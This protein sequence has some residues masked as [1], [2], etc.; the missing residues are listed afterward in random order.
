MRPG[1]LLVSG[2]W[3]RPESRREDGV[4]K[5]L[6]HRLWK[7]ERHQPHSEEGGGWVDGH[8]NSILSFKKMNVI[9]ENRDLAC[10]YTTKHS[11]RGK[12]KRVF[13]VG[14]HG[15]TT[16]NPTTLEVTNQWPYGDICGIGPVGKGQGTEFNLTFRKG[17]GKK[18]ETLKFSTE[19]RMELLT[20]ALRF[21][22]DFSEGKITGRR[23]NCYKQH[24][25]DTRRAVSLE[26][27]PGGIDQID[28]QTNRV[29][30]S[31]DYRSI[32]GFAELS[33]YQGG[34][35]ILHGGFNRLHLFASEHRDD[36]IRCAIEHA[37]NYI[38]I[39]LR[40]R[41][42]PLT[43]EVFSAERLGKYSSDDSITSLAEFV[44]QKISPRHQEPVK[45]I[46]ALTETC[47][48][49]RDPASYNIVTIKPFGEVFALICDVENPQ[50]FTVEFIRGQ[51]RKFS[52]TER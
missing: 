36:I 30:C 38:G 7:T 49:E 50:I 42:D 39:T 5:H 48:V 9:K 37:G 44:V 40:L 47:L 4:I 35:C 16:Y 34:F 3:Q 27:T 33:D 8:T 15:I 43:F 14:T 13:S 1:T 52:S 31:Y 32:E 21:R 45:R 51:I 12:Y 20:E 46:L 6:Q 28:P 25:S 18:S 23:Y 2:T 24:W 41:K 10:F 11:W 26:V 22:T 19:H 29:L 17:S